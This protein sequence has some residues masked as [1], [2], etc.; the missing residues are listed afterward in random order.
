[1]PITH[2]VARLAEVAGQLGAA[3]EQHARG[4]R[5]RLPV[6]QRADA[7]GLTMVMHAELDAAIEE[8]AATIA[9][10]GHV[11]A[12]GAGC[13]SC[14]VSP[15]LVGEGEAVT[16]A[17]WLS[18]PGHAEIKARF[19][20]KL[21]AWKAGVGDAGR[22]LGRA[23]TQEELRAA[24]LEL[25][26]RGV[27]CAFNHEGLC[28]IYEARPARC[29]TTHALDDNTHCGATG[30]GQVAYYQ[31]ARTEMTFGEQEPMR[32]AMHQ[33]LRSGADYELLCSAVERLL[34]GTA[35]VGRN[36]PCPC[37]SGQKYKRC[38]GR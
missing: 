19:L 22:A 8:R 31:H 2:D 3:L 15:L 9:Q 18:L 33:A 4:E 30:D 1:M 10:E 5:V 20:A 21:P 29:R 35:N 32:A 23:R 34:G 28:S 36:D 6:L 38:H 13:S 25:K 16:V 17:E 11:L 24:A 37:G 7:A 14:C 27:M 26:R 12:C